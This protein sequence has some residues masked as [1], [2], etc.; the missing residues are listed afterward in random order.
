MLVPVSW[1][2]PDRLSRIL[3]GYSAGCGWILAMQA[4]LLSSE[5]RIQR[6]QGLGISTFANRTTTS[7]SS[8]FSLNS[9]PPN[10]VVF[11]GDGPTSKGGTWCT[12]IYKGSMPWSVRGGT[13][14][15][16]AHS[17]ML[18][19]LPLGRE[20]WQPPRARQSLAI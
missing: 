17:G 10:P 5:I 18:A 4:S 13:L 16:V 14:L 8:S 6:R 19:T 20:S 2:T 12:A 15:L 7:S 11:S 1:L 9:V 3:F